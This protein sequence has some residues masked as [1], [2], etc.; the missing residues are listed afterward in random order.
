[1]KDEMIRRN[2][3]M[4]QEDRAKNLI[5]T[6]VGR[7]GEKRLVKQFAEREVERMRK[8]GRGN[9]TGR[10]TIT[11]RG[12]GTTTASVRGRG[13]GREVRGT[14]L[15]VEDVDYSGKE[16]RTATSRTRLNS[17]RNR[18]MEDDPE[19]VGEMPAAKH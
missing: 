1:M 2:K 7:K 11:V 13:L 18:E 9:G 19:I 12:R 3:E 17:K 5:W 6:V 10:Q 4:S 8:Q 14:G 15:G 16:E